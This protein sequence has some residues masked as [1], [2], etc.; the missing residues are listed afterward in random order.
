[1]DLLAGRAVVRTMHPF[2]ASDLDKFDPETAL[3]HGLLP[4]AVA[5]DRPD[6]VLRAMPTNV[7]RDMFTI[8]LCS[9]FVYNAK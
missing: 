3:T 5:V 2:M 4:L 9:R 8:S 1:V 7:G 6:D